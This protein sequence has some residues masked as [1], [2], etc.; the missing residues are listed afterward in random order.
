[1]MRTALVQSLRCASRVSTRVCT[2]AVR[3][4]APSTYTAVTRSIPSY[5]PAGLRFYSAPSGLSR[6]EV[7]GRILDIL[8][9]FDKVCN[10]LTIHMF[11]RGQMLTYIRFKTLQRS[12]TKARIYDSSLTYVDHQ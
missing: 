5:R 8:K 10:N 6:D 12:A 2:P 11:V 1:M 9:N 7:E 3:S 4:I